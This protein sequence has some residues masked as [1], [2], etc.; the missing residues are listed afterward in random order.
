MNSQHTIALLADAA[1]QCS[2]AAYDESHS[3][4]L[5]GVEFAT[6]ERI[7]ASE[8][9]LAKTIFTTIV[10]PGAAS[11]PIFMFAIRGSASILDHMTN[12]NGGTRD[13]QDFI[14]RSRG[15]YNAFS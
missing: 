5:E 2:L 14:V 10:K 6:S 4:Q 12:L 11:K 7:G 13:V 8:A 1:M 3:P 15:A 9:S